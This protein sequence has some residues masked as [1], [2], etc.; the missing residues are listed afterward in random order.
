MKAL[1]RIPINIKCIEMKY[2]FSFFFSFGGWMKLNILSCFE[3]VF[4][5]VGFDK[6]NI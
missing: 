5:M 1:A 3:L 6:E 2:F 4:W